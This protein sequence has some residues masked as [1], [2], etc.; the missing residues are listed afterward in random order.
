MLGFYHCKIHILPLLM[1][2][3][4]TVDLLL[5]PSEALRFRCLSLQ[6][7]LEPIPEIRPG[8]LRAIFPFFHHLGWQNHESCFPLELPFRLL[9]FAAFS[10]YLAYPRRPK[11]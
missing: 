1:G 5:A 2:M 4:V 8:R 7:L 3:N 10:V 6:I 9:I 11:S